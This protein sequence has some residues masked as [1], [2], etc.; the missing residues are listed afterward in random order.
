MQDKLEKIIS[1]MSA[2]W[3]SLQFRTTS[4]GVKCFESAI[5]SVLPHEKQQHLVRSI[6]LLVTQGLRTINASSAP[7]SFTELTTF[8]SILQDHI[9]KGTTLYVYTGSWSHPV[10]D[11]QCAREG[12]DYCEHEVW[13]SAAITDNFDKA[14]DAAV[15]ILTSGVA[16]CLPPFGT[17]T[18]VVIEMFDGDDLIPMGSWTWDKCNGR[19]LFRS[20]EDRH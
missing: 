19:I 12:C 6:G 10:E 4:E 8:T 17:N 2:S 5:L 7:D 11:D 15:E 13:R 9:Q 16:D 14:K 20:P 1:V 3:G 18:E